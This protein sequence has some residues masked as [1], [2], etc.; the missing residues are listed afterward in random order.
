MAQV[1]QLPDNT[2]SLSIMGISVI[3][4]IS[5]ISSCAMV[6]GGVVPYIP[7]YWDILKTRNAEGFS[8]HVCLALL[9]ANI[10]RILFWYVDNDRFML[11]LMACLVNF[12]LDKIESDQLHHNI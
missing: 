9:L 1:P 2:D 11:S 4:V 5:W 10:L 12:T 7:Q 6:F 8:I 3:N